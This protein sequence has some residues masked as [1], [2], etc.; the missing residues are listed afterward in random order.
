M[1]R[2]A[3]PHQADAFRRKD[4]PPNRF[5]APPSVADAA[6]SNRPLTMWDTLAESSFP[7]RVTVKCVLFV[8]V[9]GM[10][11]FPHPVL[12]VRHVDHF[13]HHDALIQ[14]D[15]PAMPEI[16]AAIN[17]FLPTNA[18]PKQEF[19]AVERYVYRTIKYQYDWYNWGNLDYWP[20]AAEVWERKRED[21]DG[22]AVLAASILR[23]RGYK[24]ARLVANLNHVWV[25]VADTEIMGPQAEKNLARVGDKIV[26]T[27]PGWRT[28]IDVVGQISAFPVLRSLILLFT[29]T[30]LLYHPC[31]HKGGFCFVTALGCIGFV[32]LYEWSHLR[33]QGD[34]P[35]FPLNFFL[36]SALL[37]ASAITALVM[38]LFLKRR[39]ERSAPRKSPEPEKKAT[40]GVKLAV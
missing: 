23:S 19:A 11:L 12:F 9:L 5:A 14:P 32:F 4:E 38:P 16:N 13:R 33:M 2:G 34:F 8:I 37:L 27:L 3:L 28:F 6:A 22:R 40:G 24:D 26:V 39:E 35:G 25:A 18:T 29:G 36:G 15:L 20:T 1:A 17:K 10:V 7:A 21:C 31:R 30:L